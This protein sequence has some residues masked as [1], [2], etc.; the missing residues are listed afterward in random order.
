[1]V[2]FYRKLIPGFAKLVLPLS[3]RRRLTP[4]GL[5]TLNNLEKQS[6]S[7][8]IKILGELTEL[9]HPQP[10]CTQYQLVTD[11]RQIC[12][13]CCLTSGHKWKSNTNRILLKETDDNTDEIFHFW[14]WTFSSIFVSVTFSPPH[15]RSWSITSDGS[16]TNMRCIPQSKNLPNQIDNKD[17]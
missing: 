10:T 5:I 12:S 9:S 7:N 6:F 3:E 2:G 11:S 16:Q 14:P 1:M 13:R 8:I 17:S 15:R 4:K